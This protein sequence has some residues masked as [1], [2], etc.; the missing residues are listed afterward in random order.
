MVKPSMPPLQSLK[1]K[2][3]EVSMLRRSSNLTSM[4]EKWVYTLCKTY[5]TYFQ[6]FPSIFASLSVSWLWSIWIWH[7]NVFVWR[8]V[9]RG[10]DIGQGL[11]EKKEKSVRNRSRHG[12]LHGVKW[13]F[14]GEE[15]HRGDLRLMK[16]VINLQVV[17]ERMWSGCY[18]HIYL[19]S[20]LLHLCTIWGAS[21]E[22]LMRW[23]LW[24]HVQP[25]QSFEVDAKCNNIPKFSAWS[26]DSLDHL[27]KIGG[28]R[29]F[30]M[31]VKSYH[32]KAISRKKKLVRRRRHICNSIP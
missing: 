22:A 24:W 19:G 18:Q 13:K 27:W 31:H 1:P 30:I 23:R 20:L 21:W 17:E 32:R 8:T 29:R 12:S 2:M 6:Y 5:H 14:W 28:L 3:K 16:K 15:W 4:A 9:H 7:V 26:M 25:R 10:N 11:G